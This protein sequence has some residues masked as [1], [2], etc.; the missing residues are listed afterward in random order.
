MIALCN[1]RQANN[2]SAMAGMRQTQEEAFLTG[3]SGKTSAA[4][5]TEAAA[6]SGGGSSA[7][8]AAAGEGAAGAGGA[9]GWEAGAG[10]AAAGGGVADRVDVDAHM[11]ECAE[12]SP[13]AFLAYMYLRMINVVYA[14]IDTKHDRTFGNHERYQALVPILLSILTVCNATNYCPMLVVEIERWL[15]ASEN[16]KKVFAHGVYVMTSAR[17]ASTGWFD[18]TQEKVNN[19]IRKIVGKDYWQGKEKQIVRAA[20]R[21]ADLQQRRA[22]ARE[23]PLFRR[24]ASA[25]E[26]SA[27][28]AL[29]GGARKRTMALSE[30]YWKSLEWWRKSGIWKK[31]AKIT[32]KHGQTWD[33]SFMK[34]WD[35]LA[36]NP[37]M[38]TLLETADK[39]HREIAQAVGI[40][41]EWDHKVKLATIPATTARA[42]DGGLNEW[43]RIYGVS[44]ED[45]NSMKVQEL[46][47]EL[48]CLKA[49]WGK[50][51]DPTGSL[52]PSPVLPEALQAHADSSKKS[53]GHWAKPLSEWSDSQLGQGKP[54]LM[55]LLGA[56]RGALIAKGVLVVPPAPSEAT[57]GSLQADADLLRRQLQTQPLLRALVRANK[58]GR[59][60]SHGPLH[61]G[62]L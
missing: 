51:K 49:E 33:R 22:A 29:V 45:L 50:F 2:L 27:G 44:A 25:P 31:G 26:L 28:A 8:G 17:G 47:D 11:R 3:M 24:S 12:E 5:E 16:E 54:R 32:G 15:L 52:I 62:D 39:R 42:A 13:L 30:A 40:K 23:Q 4:E 58:R 21:L 10:G 38:L 55:A 20:I 46:Q 7:G 6:A 48:R 53:E 37:E 41:M 1:W 57:M 9:G 35:G 56:A 61:D 18:E 14:V 59:E 43:K 36:L 19:G 34:T 60:S